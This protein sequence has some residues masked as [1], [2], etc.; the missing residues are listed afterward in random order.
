M[1]KIFLI[2][3]ILSF[4]FGCVSYK[5][6]RQL[7]DRLDKVE[8]LSSYSME[9]DMEAAA[10]VGASA[11][12]S[13]LT[14]LAS[15]PA[16]SDELYLNDDGS[17]KKIQVINLLKALQSSL[18]SFEMHN[19]NLDPDIGSIAGLVS[20]ADKIP[21]YT[22]AGTA[23]V[24]DFTALARA[25]VGL[26]SLTDGGILLGSGSGAITPMD[27]L[28]D[29]QMIVG[30]GTTD[31]VAESGATLRT[32]IGVGTGDSPQF[33]GIELGHASDTTVVRLQRP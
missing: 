4:L 26:S 5:E 9:D 22:G 33:T 27:V 11:K 6:Y 10:Q 28:T 31:P 20:A 8:G 24:A 13:A 17:S 23:A 3:V 18:T 16:E 30:D 29:G 19:D 1:K 7:E 15:A 14:E 21:Y 12:L 2:F 25:I 32:S